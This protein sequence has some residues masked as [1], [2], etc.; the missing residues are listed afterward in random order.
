MWML[1]SES[2]ALRL[3]GFDSHMYTFKAVERHFG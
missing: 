2:I 3:L 1:S